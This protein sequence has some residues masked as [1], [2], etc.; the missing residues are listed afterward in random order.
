MKSIKDILNESILDPNLESNVDDTVKLMEFFQTSQCVVFT[1]AN[2]QDLSKFIEVNPSKK[3]YSFI[4]NGDVKFFVNE[5]VVEALKDWTLDVVDIKDHRFY[6]C[7]K[8]KTNTFNTPTNFFPRKVDSIMEVQYS[9]MKVAEL[10]LSK[11][12]TALSNA[13]CGIMIEQGWPTPPRVWLD[14]LIWND[15]PISWLQVSLQIREKTEFDLPEIGSLGLGKTGMK[16]FVQKAITDP[17]VVK[18]VLG[19]R[20]KVDG[21]IRE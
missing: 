20:C 9:N 16:I 5:G 2:D 3:T 8:C 12:K 13:P 1:R 15:N 6:L 14:K 10:D 4:H 11:D 21:S 7:F 19:P 17:T 18:N